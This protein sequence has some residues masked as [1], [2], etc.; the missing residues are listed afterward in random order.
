[1]I[2]NQERNKM[3][4]VHDALPQSVYDSFNEFIFSSDRKLFAKLASK[5]YFAEL[6]KNVPGDYIELGVFKGSGM[7]GW[8]KSNE[9]I[10]VNNKRVI[11]FD[12]FDN[13]KLVEGIGTKDKGLMERLFSDRKFDSFGYEEVLERIITD[14]GFSNYLLIKGSVFETV[15][16]FL[17]NRPGFRASV[18]NFDLDTY[19]PTKFCL[20]SF[21]DRL[22]TGGVMIF[23][24]YATDEWT[25]SDAVDEFINEHGLNLIS[26]PYQFPSAY[27]IK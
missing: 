22:V 23:D 25:E 27:L 7:L 4:F 14:V 16:N 12:I 6:T 13:V 15:P 3:K 8:L 18:I 9:L 2:L 10:S 1:M 21:W 11:G 26:T 20:N 17:E 5:L 24:E 19:E